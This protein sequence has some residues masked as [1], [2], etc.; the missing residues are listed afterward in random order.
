ML[1]RVFAVLIGLLFS[2]AVHGLTCDQIFTD[3][4]SD[5]LGDDALTLPDG[6]F[7]NVTDLV[8]GR[9]GCNRNGG[10]YFNPG[11]YG[12]DHGDFNNR[13]AIYT[14]GNT[15]R[16]YFKTL[17][18]TNS[19][20]NADGDA[21]ALIIYVDGNLSVAGKNTINGIVYVNGNVS[22]SGNATIDGALAA[23]GSLAVGGNGEVDFDEDIF[24]DADFGDL[25]SN[26]EQT[27]FHLQFGKAATSTG[28]GYVSFTS[29]FESGVTPL[30]FVMPTISPVNTNYDQPSSTQIS[31]ISRTGFRFNQIDPPGNAGLGT[32]MPDIHWIAVSPGEHT[33]SDGTRLFAGK[34]ASNQA[35]KL[36]NFSWSNIRA[37]AA[38]QVILSQKQTNHNQCWLTSVAELTSSGFRLALDV[39]EELL[40]K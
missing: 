30:V 19:L 17:S 36:A 11:D 26:I 20:L 7:N 6:I 18:L 1:I 24:E 37:D 10:K 15:T 23:G 3:P 2:Q 31:N 27:N 12:Y 9:T 22:L 8:C 16:L 5:N 38:F 13:S 32:V 34:I 33:L 4:P 39:S 40:I 28:D 35:L 14:N 25:C 21:S 29:P